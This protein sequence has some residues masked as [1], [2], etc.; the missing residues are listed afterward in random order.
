MDITE[1]SILT[2]NGGSSSIKFAVYHFINDQSLLLKGEI[3]KIGSAAASLTFS[4]TGSDRKEIISIEAFNYA[5]AANYLLDWL[6][7]RIDF[8]LIK[9]AGH[10]IVHGMNYT[11]PEIISPQF[12]SE[13]ERNIAYDPEHLP[14][15][16]CLIKL[17]SARYP[18]LLQIACFDTA[19]HQSMPAV[20]RLLSI[21]RRYQAEGLKR[22]GFHGL[23]YTYLLEEL[24]RIGGSR[25][26][27]GKI[28]LAHLGSGASLAA[29]REGKSVDTSM[30][31]TPASGLPMSTRAGDLDPGVAAFLMQ[32]G[33]LSPN[34]FNDLINHESGLLGLSETTGDM[35]ELL[36]IEQTDIRAAEAIDF[37]CYQ[38]KK[39]IGSFAAVLEGLD[40]LVFSG[41]IGENAA[42]VRWRICNG[43]QFLGIQIDEE[44]NKDDDLVISSAQSNVTVFVIRTDEQSMIARQVSTIL[45]AH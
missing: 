3:A 25:V 38:A 33:N 14:G 11:R 4:Q 36:K 10:R 1:S 35:Q 45:N 2:I 42:M 7:Q 29:I 19:F 40:T 16:I 6:E 17:F 39:W 21:P 5:A 41:G 15:E 12:L 28:I 37:F 30:G 18:G 23:S 9:A 13:L 31:F 34:A 22:Y 26:R 20:A 24:D 44:K 43:L 27:G 8:R 32:T